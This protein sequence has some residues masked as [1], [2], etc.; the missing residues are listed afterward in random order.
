MMENQPS[1]EEEKPSSSNAV[2]KIYGDYEVLKPIGKGKFAIVYR[3]QKIS[4]QTIVALKRISVDMIDDKAREKCLKEVRLL[5]SLDHPNV[6]KYMDSFISE[7]DLVIVVEWAAAGDLKRQLRKA[8]ERGVGF[9]ERVIWKYFS[10]ICEAIKHMHEKRVM[11]RDLKP[12]NIFLTLDGTVKVGDLGLSRELSEHTVQAHSKVGTPLYMSPEVL[13]GD[14]Y[15]FK[16]DIWSLGCL[17][18]ELAMLKSPFK[19]E[20]LNLYGLFQKISAGDFTPVPDNYSVELRSLVNSMLSNKSEDRPEIAAVCVTASAMREKLARKR[21]VSST[22]A[23]ANSNSTS[24]AN[25]QIGDSEQQAPE[26]KFKDDQSYNR[27]RVDSNRSTSHGASTVKND[28]TR[29]E[30]KEYETEVK[31]G[32]NNNWDMHRN[33]SI[34]PNY[35]IGDNDNVQDRYLSNYQKNQRSNS[36]HFEDDEMVRIPSGSNENVVVGPAPDEMDRMGR[37]IGNNDV[38]EERPDIHMN[39][40]MPRQSGNGY[41]RPDSAS[42]NGRNMNSQSKMSRVQPEKHFRHDISSSSTA[43]GDENLMTVGVDNGNGSGHGT[44]FPD[45]PANTKEKSYNATKEYGDKNEK[46]NSSG[47]GFRDTKPSGNKIGGKASDHMNGWD[48]AGDDRKEPSKNG[49]GSNNQFENEPYRELQRNEVSR[50]ESRKTSSRDRV[51][52]DRSRNNSRGN[53]PNERKPTK[54]TTKTSDKSVMESDFNS[55]TRVTRNGGEVNYQTMVAT[56]ELMELLYV[57]LVLLRYPF[58]GEQQ[59]NARMVLTPL[60]FLCDLS[61][62]GGSGNIDTSSQF[63]RF[64]EVSIWILDQLGQSHLTATWNV[65]DDT[66]VMLAKQVLYAAQACGVGIADMTPSSLIPGNGEKV[67]RLLNELADCL[68]KKRSYTFRKPDYSSVSDGAMSHA[69]EYEDAVSVHSHS[70]NCFALYACR[71]YLY[72]CGFN[73]CMFDTCLYRVRKKSKIQNLMWK[74]IPMCCLINLWSVWDRRER[75]MEVQLQW[76]EA[77]V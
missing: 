1:G 57:K 35:G 77:E 64:V 23:G 67:C 15:D 50:G 72:M 69:Q 47:G 29:S 28:N 20:G 43:E 18:Y 71:C 73:Y 74:M 68:L 53:E 61:I 62:L 9:E 54:M 60:H 56:S 26:A 55:T 25:P 21:S 27:D 33:G 45:V 32:S 75:I 6:I 14:G 2:K 49:F 65:D 34:E 63:S 70:V 30:A 12:A 19:A 59:S 8:Q 44:N 24:V 31:R 58:K 17:L 39:S 48:F 46:K 76:L 16:S 42:R 51:V 41:S 22:N 3:A 52:Q 66:P 11:H 37:Y 13:R 38:K 7:N 40:H 5:A 36:N 10:Q 4:D